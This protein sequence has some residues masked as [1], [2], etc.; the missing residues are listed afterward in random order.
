LPIARQRETDYQSVTVTTP[1]I[2]I[3][4]QPEDVEQVR[5]WLQRQIADGKSD[6]LVEQVLKVL[7]QMR[8]LNTALELRNAELLRKLY[9]QRSEK[10]DPDQLALFYGLL[11]GLAPAPTQ[12]PAAAE[13]EQSAPA[14]EPSAQPADAPAGQA[15]DATPRPKKKHPGR[16]PLPASL[17]REPIPLTPPPE[18]LTC[19]QHGPK[20]L[21]RVQ[22]SEVLE[23][24]PSSFKVLRYEQQIYGCSE[25]CEGQLVTA[26]PANKIIERGLPG[27]GLMADMLVKK[28]RFGL[29]LERIRIMYQRGGVELSSSTMGS[30][31]TAAA[32]L[33]EPIAKLLAQIVLQAHVLGT[34]DT[35]LPVLDRDHPNGIKRGHM[36]AYVSDGGYIYYEFTPDWSSE[37]PREFLSRR[38]GIIQADDYAGY[39]ALFGPESGRIKAGCWAHCRRKV[40]AALQAGDQRASYA[41]GLIALIYD[42]ERQATEDQVSVE[43]RTRRRQLGTRPIIDQLRDWG[44]KLQLVL[45]PKSPLGKA[46]GYMMGQWDSLIV[47]LDDGRVSPDNN[48]VE[49]QMRPIAVGRK[50]YLFAGSEAGG[51]RAAIVYTIIGNCLM[52]GVDP[53]DYLQDVLLKLASGWPMSR[54]SELLP[55]AWA[56]HHRQ[57]GHPEADAPVIPAPA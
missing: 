32:D 29:P 17:P 52:A 41:L 40:E 50:A 26:E 2:Q 4:K 12:D 48:W 7:E 9:G 47:F 1:R 18:Q 20:V 31:V 51:Q 57:E 13:Q 25:G 3:P 16:R 54:L 14:T 5:A 42:N 37:K 11:T 56:E 38:T 10:I 8:Q 33:L 55:R 44:R 6:V 34:D 46:V 19:P 27:P 24:V 43:E 49:R 22:V 15:P 39:A 45:V 30:W 28:Y 53:W 35:G 21:I 36:W 23:F